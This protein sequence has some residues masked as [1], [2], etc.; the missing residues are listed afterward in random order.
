MEEETSD[1]N[2]RKVWTKEAKECEELGCYEC[3][4][5]LH[6][7][8]L[9]Q[10]PT[11]RDVWLNFITYERHVIPPVPSAPTP[12]PTATTATTTAT[13]NTHSTTTAPPTTPSPPID[14]VS[15]RVAALMRR[16]VAVRSKDVLL[17][18]MAAKEAWKTNNDVDGART[19]LEEAFQMNPNNEE[20][21]LAGAKIEQEEGEYDRARMLLK[22]AREETP[23]MRVWMKSATIE[24]LD[25]CIGEAMILLKQ[26]RELYPKSAK[27]FIMSI[28]TQLDFNTSLQDMGTK[29]LQM[30]A[31]ASLGFLPMSI[32]NLCNASLTACPSS[33][34]LWLLACHIEEREAGMI[35]ARSMLEIGRQRNPT[36]EDLWNVAID[37]ELRSKNE[38]MAESLMAKALESC[39]SSGVLASKHIEMAPRGVRQSR[40]LALLRSK[41]YDGNST[42]L[43]AVAKMLWSLGKGSKARSWFEKAVNANSD[44]GDVWSEY[45]AFEIHHG[46]TEE[47]QQKLIQRCIEAGPK[48][49]KMLFCPIVKRI[50]IRSPLITIETAIK[51]A[52]STIVGPFL[53]QHK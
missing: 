15:T 24:R 20:L 38:Q 37:L 19:L 43:A 44:D 27:I 49:G 50:E 32:R 34:P 2:K 10:Y 36:S 46:A 45:L 33:V 35:R 47:Q 5:T 16:A 42:V 21:L 13:T 52:A 31:T 8:I 53:V 11:R 39:P 1:A 6:E 26:G 17:W 4:R 40:A 3:G 14:N 29:Q 23:S 7:H 28:Q 48:H 30:E 51:E 41:R 18:L 12:A 9:S 25:G 22:R